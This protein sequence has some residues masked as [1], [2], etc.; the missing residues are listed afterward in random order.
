MGKVTYI[1]IDPGKT[2]GIAAYDKEGNCVWMY[3]VKYD[4]IIQFLKQVESSM[5]D[6]STGIKAVIIE[7]FRLFPHKRTEHNFSDLATARVI[8]R[9]EAFCEDR[10][11]KLVKQ[12]PDTKTTGFAYLGQKEPSRGAKLA[13][14]A[15]ANAHGTYWLLNSGIMSGRKLLENRKGI[16]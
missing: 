14:A 12:M 6:F 1:A 10:D 5:M 15:V 9:I 16:K 7:D 4:G 13:H 2:N 11:I 8:G 3:E